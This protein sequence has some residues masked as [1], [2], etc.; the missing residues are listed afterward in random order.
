[1][2]IPRITPVSGKRITLP[3]APDRAM[4]M[5]IGVRLKRAVEAVVEQLAK[6]DSDDGRIG[7]VIVLPCG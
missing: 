7:Q 3:I 1:M 5:Q 2:P 4:H 6:A